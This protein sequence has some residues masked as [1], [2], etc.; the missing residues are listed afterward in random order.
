MPI[1][2]SADIG[3]ELPDGGMNP[4]LEPLSGELSEPVLNY[5]REQFANQIECA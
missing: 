1:D 3:F 2:E 5:W 4:S